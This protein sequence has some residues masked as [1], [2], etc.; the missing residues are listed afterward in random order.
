[1]HN[2]YA[3]NH[4]CIQNLT[5]QLVL[6]LQRLILYQWVWHFHNREYCDTQ[7]IHNSEYSYLLRNQFYYPSPFS[8]N[9]IW[10]PSQGTFFEAILKQ[11]YQGPHRSSE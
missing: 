8:L 6:N 4:E 11:F 1:M 7:N 10:L 9:V 5:Y 3:L 2:W